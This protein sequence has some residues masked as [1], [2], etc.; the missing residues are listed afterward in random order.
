MAPECVAR[1]RM[2]VIDGEAE[3]VSRAE[4]AEGS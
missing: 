2:T 4:L 1:A 3:E